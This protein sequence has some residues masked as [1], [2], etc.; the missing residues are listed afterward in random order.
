MAICATP[1]ADSAGAGPYRGLMLRLLMLVAGVILAVLIVVAI[2][3]V[4]WW[5]M[6]VALVIFAIGLLF[7]V[8]RIGRWSARRR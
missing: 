8:F 4:L 5:L 2:L 3:H 1:G 6:T 7:G